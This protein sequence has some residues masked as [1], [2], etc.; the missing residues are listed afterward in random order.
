MGRRPNGMSLERK[1]NDGDYC[2]TN[3]KWATAKEQGRNTRSNKLNPE[4]VLKIKEMRSRGMKY[5]Q[6]LTHFPTI[7]KST[8]IMAGSGR[9][10]N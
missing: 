4:I 8:A 9:T 7:K 2:P 10:W 3:V 5:S 1:N 6:I